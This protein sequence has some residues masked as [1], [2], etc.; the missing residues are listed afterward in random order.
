MTSSPFGNKCNGISLRCETMDK[1]RSGDP[2][3]PPDFFPT[4]SVF[5]DHVTELLRGVDLKGCV[6]FTF[7]VGG[8]EEVAF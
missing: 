3:G 7:P 4:P 8:N 1:S 5:K 2:S 6:A